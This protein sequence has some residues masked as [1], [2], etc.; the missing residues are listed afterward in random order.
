MNKFG[1]TFSL[2]VKNRFYCLSIS[3]ILSP[4]FP[5]TSPMQWRKLRYSRKEVWTDKQTDRRNDIEPTLWTISVRKRKHGRWRC[6]MPIHMSISQTQI[7]RQATDIHEVRQPRSASEHLSNSHASI[8][9]PTS[10][11]AN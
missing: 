3:F 6:H 5:T 4:S 7:L 9:F 10:A 2:H 11:S 1:F 8:S